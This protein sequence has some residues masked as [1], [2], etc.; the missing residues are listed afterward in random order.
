M[1]G[2]NNLDSSN[3]LAGAWV[4]LDESSA[5]DNDMRT[6]FTNKKSGCEN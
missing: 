2:P 4:Y 6:I 5:G 1:V 3:I